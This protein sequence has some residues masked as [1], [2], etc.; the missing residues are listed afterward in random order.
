MEHRRR[1]AEIEE[2]LKHH[3]LT[4]QRRAIVET[5]LAH[6]DGHLSADEV[7]A[8]VKERF[9]EMGIATVYRTLDILT[10]QHVVHKLNFGDGRSRYELVEP[11]AHSHHHLI[12][13]RCGKIIEVKDDLLQKLEESVS[14]ENDFEVLDH[15][16]QFYG[17]CSDC[18]KGKKADTRS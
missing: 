14:D 11:E 3:R 10:A 6:P 13:M 1:I 2:K 9:P 4:P 16:L 17:Y 5:I 18:R 15:R 7:C 8:I 12:C